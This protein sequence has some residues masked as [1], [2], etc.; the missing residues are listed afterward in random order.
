MLGDQF[1]GRQ[2]T[3]LLHHHYVRFIRIRLKLEQEEETTEEKHTD[4]I[5]VKL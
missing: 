1:Q 4:S 2:Q 5:G 3:V